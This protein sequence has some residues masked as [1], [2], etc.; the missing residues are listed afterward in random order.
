MDAPLVPEEIE[1][2]GERLTMRERRLAVG[3]MDGKTHVQAIKDAG[4]PETAH[5]WGQTAYDVL[6]K[7][8][9]ADYMR[10]L[11]DAAGLSD[12]AL[13]EKAKELMGATRTELDRNG[14]IRDMGPDGQTQFKA[15]ELAF[16]VRDRMPSTR[17]EVEHT[18]KGAIMLRTDEQWVPDPF[19][20]I[21]EGEVTDQ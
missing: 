19:A 7:P 20:E 5:G 12:M 14:D 13:V 15:L 21:V 8:H 11:M 4:Y 18:V 2:L 17:H 6:K 16:R 3:L 1:K 9:V 10:A